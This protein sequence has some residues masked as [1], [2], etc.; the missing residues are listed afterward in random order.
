[1]SIALDL[2]LFLSTPTGGEDLVFLSQKG[3]SVDGG[4]APVAVGRG[5]GPCARAS[6]NI[7]HAHAHA[8]A[9][10]ALCRCKAAASHM[11]GATYQ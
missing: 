3:M 7:V 6:T 1:L 4:E 9:L 2:L 10:D 8:H 11:I 5:G